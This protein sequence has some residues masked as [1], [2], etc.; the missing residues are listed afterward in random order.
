[1]T[2]RGRRRRRQTGQ[3]SSGA[4]WL[5]LAPATALILGVVLFP[6]IQLFRASRGEYSITGLRTGD[7]G[8]SNYTAVLNHPSLEVVVRNTVIWVV[9]VVAATILISLGLAQL[10]IK[11]FPGRRI[12]RWAVIVPWAA[13][14]IITSQLFVLL[15]DYN[16]GIINHLLKKVGLIETS[17]DFLGDDRLTLASMI[18]VG[19]F[20]S[21]PFTTFVFIAGLNAIP[22]DV[23]EA[24]RVDG[25]SAWKRYRHV[26]L[27]LLRPALMV[28]SVLNVIYVF[29]SFPIVYT[30]NDRNPG[31]AHDTTITFMYKLA[32][33]SQEKDVGMSAAAGI[34][35]VLLILV[36]IAVYMKVVNWQEQ[37]R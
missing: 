13:S 28:A 34:G 7:A 16:Y 15:Y 31:Y 2:P 21:L 8:W 17:I 26:T 19:I 10:L 5:W 9:V 25:A 30:L 1:M 29:N 23:M 11:Q 18:V 27:P 24:A 6:A 22:G 33:E 32:F 36:V 12:V 37:T 4:A 20:V 14:L 3:I 35:N